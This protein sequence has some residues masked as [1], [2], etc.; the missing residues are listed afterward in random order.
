MLANVGR[1]APWS[2]N[3]N[4]TGAELMDFLQPN[5]EAKLSRMRGASKSSVVATPPISDVSPI[6]SPRLS[7]VPLEVLRGADGGETPSI[8]V[9]AADEIQSTFDG[10]QYGNSR[11][12]NANEKGNK[13]FRS[14]H[15]FGRKSTVD[16]GKPIENRRCGPEAGT[17]SQDMIPTMAG[18]KNKA[19]VPVVHLK[20]GTFDRVAPWLLDVKLRTNE[21]FQSCTARRGDYVIAVCYVTDVCGVYGAP[22]G[23]NTVEKQLAPALSDRY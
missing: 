15:C 18:C 14:C 20:L 13:H 1:S 12:P 23:H 16:G 10:Y 2:T 22:N 7:E 9:H 6:L 17:V 4:T 11:K 21:Q 3:I 5:W 19:V 8:E